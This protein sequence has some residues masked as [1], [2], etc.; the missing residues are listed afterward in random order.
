MLKISDPKAYEAALSMNSSST[1]LFHPH[2]QNFNRVSELNE[3]FYNLH[4][5]PDMEKS[6]GTNDEMSFPILP[7]A[8]S[9]DWGMKTET[10]LYKP[11]SDPDMSASYLKKIWSSA[12]QTPDFTLSKVKIY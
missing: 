3:N 12:N 9:P 5:Q 8:D 10:T 7:K 6:M 11:A 2:E 4:V 1:S